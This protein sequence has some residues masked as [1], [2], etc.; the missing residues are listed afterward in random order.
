MLIVYN[1]WSL[2][3]QVLHLKDGFCMDHQKLAEYIEILCQSGC[4]AVNATISAMEKNQ[5]TNLT[6]DLT[7]EEQQLV[8]SELKAIMS[9]YKH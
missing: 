3:K 7:E 4:D 6:Q 8:L 2:F 9:V 1:E 5:P